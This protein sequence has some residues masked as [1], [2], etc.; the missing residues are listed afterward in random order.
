[1]GYV[2]EEIV[3]GSPAIDFQFRPGETWAKIRFAKAVTLSFRI[4]SALLCWK[5]RIAT[6]PIVSADWSTVKPA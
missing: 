2:A 4:R 6:D 1:L 5:W 3:P